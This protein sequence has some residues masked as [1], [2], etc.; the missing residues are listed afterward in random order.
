MDENKELKEEQKREFFEIP[1]KDLFSDFAEHIE[2][3]EN[4]RIFVSGKF[5]IGKTYFL[6]KFFKEQQ[7]KYEVFHLF[8]VYYQINSSEDIIEL[9]QYDLLVELTKKNKNLFNENKVE[10]IGDL[11][12]LF[13]VWVKTNFSIPKVLSRGIS[14]M[15]DI[16][17]FYNPI[18]APLTRLGRRV[19]D[20]TD[21]FEK[22]QKFK[23]ELESGE[24]GFIEKFLNKSRSKKISETS[25]FSELLKEKIIEQK[26]DKKSVLVLDDLDRID[27]EHIFRILNTFSV[28]FD[29]ETNEENPNKFGF[30][31]IV[32]I[33][34]RQNIESI[35]Y[36]KYGSNTNFD[37]YFNKF[38]SIKTYDFNNE[39]IISNYVDVLISKM[40]L[41]DKTLTNAMSDDGY[42]KIFLSGI[43]KEWLLLKTKEKLN[44]R[45][46]LKFNKFDKQLIKEGSYYKGNTSNN[47][48]LV[49]LQFINFSIGILSSV[50]DGP[51]NLINIIKEIRD[52]S[53]LG[54]NKNERHYIFSKYFV[55]KILGSNFKDLEEIKKWNNYSLKIDDFGFRNIAILNGESGYTQRKL[56]YDLLIEYI[57]KEYF[58]E[59][60]TR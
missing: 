52:N 39:K 27:P 2:V 48:S 40:R 29:L 10:N 38:F 16:T 26:V 28:Q 13:Y 57:S 4:K 58:L 11:T 46:L 19:E 60:K 59:K 12:T 21:L 37:G 56:F 1:T 14:T 5:G 32:L 22:F 6:N 18:L 30:D 43:L 55:E 45:Q 34:D 49:V 9:L 35:F 23:K 36:H 15:F 17:A 53:R 47:E 33:G 25:Y 7:N 51:D 41:E 50:S 24:K 31:K 3:D 20:I 44:L 8:P 54:S 42:S